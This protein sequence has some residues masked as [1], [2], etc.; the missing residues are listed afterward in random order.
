VSEPV[1]PMDQDTEV[2]ER[3]DSASDGSDLTLQSEAQEYLGIVSGI[4]RSPEK[5]AELMGAW[6]K[7][8]MPG[9]LS[10]AAWIDL[11]GNRD[12]GLEIRIF[13]RKLSKWPSTKIL[14]GGLLGKETAG[15]DLSTEIYRMSSGVRVSIGVGVVTPF[16]DFLHEARPVA[17]VSFRF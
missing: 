7:A 12:E 4:I 6:F 5:I 15:L 10:S 11:K 1:D 3:D 16:D 13:E 14:I 9:R 2:I 8:H 17:V